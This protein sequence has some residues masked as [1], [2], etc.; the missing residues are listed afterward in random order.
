MTEKILVINDDDGI[1]EIT[2][3]VLQAKGYETLEAESGSMGIEQ[4]TQHLPDL[5]LLDIVMP[6]MDGF[7]TCQKL[8][9]SSITKDIPVLFFSSLTQAKD[10][11]KG[12][13]LGA[14]DF[15]NNIVDHG[16]LIARVQTHL[17]I[18]SLTRALQES[19]Q[20]LMRKQKS[21]DDDLHAAVAIQR[22]FL[23]PANLNMKGIQ[24]ASV[25]MPAHLLGGDIF[26]VIQ[27]HEG[28]M[29][30]YMIDVSGHDVPSALVTVSISQYL[31]LQ[32]AP[33]MPLLSPQETMQN[34]EKEYPIERFNR[35]FTMFYILFDP[36][37]GHFSYSSAGHPPAVL[38]S[39]EKGLKILERG[40]TV[41]GLGGGLTFEEGIE[42]LAP[43][44]KVFLYTD[45]VTEAKDLGDEL[46]GTERLYPLLEK[47][48]N[49]PVADIIQAVQTS[50]NTFGQGVNL[51]DDTSMM[52]F[53]FTLE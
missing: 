23:P 32:N 4:A 13:E 5:I 8:K 43:G 18:Q 15:I 16:E 29:V 41:I 3:F 11:I 26:N 12:L 9:S 36:A 35:Y 39:K 6:E 17:H 21:L 25:W 27:R 19:N 44:D 46:Y 38:L 48:K 2:Q 50:L 52:C 34:L 45:G 49:E 22:S 7:E 42:I 30:F 31:H 14:V 47:V 37:T 51:E 28:K 24:L 53:E 33:S 40:G 10:K 20:Q 1:R